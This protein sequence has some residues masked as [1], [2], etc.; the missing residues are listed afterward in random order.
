MVG[1]VWAFGVVIGRR[2]VGAGVVRVCAAIR[3]RRR[4]GLIL[5][6]VGV[7][8]WGRRSQWGGIRGLKTFVDISGVWGIG[9]DYRGCFGDVESVFGWRVLSRVNA[10]LLRSYLHPSLS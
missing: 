5:V 1:M 2:V 8:G 7:G 4:R 3:R 6:C 9:L 10:V